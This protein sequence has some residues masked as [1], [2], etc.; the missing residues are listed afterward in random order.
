MRWEHMLRRTIKG[1]LTGTL[2]L[3]GGCGR[4]VDLHGR[5]GG[6]GLPPPRSRRTISRPAAAPSPFDRARCRDLA[7]AIVDLIEDDKMD[8]AEFAHARNRFAAA[9]PPR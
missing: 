2:G 4:G 9:C 3:P 6:A 1:L 7:A 8:S 5:R